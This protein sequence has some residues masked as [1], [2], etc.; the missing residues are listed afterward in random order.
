ME[1]DTS[2]MVREVVGSCGRYDNSARVLKRLKRRDS[3]KD[4]N[5]DWSIR[6]VIGD[7]TNCRENNLPPPYSGVMVN[8]SIPIQILARAIRAHRT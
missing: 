2:E 4:E 5:G 6:Q 1:Q 3:C 8:L 7:N